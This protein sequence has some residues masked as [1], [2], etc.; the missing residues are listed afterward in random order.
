M[1]KYYTRFIKEYYGSSGR[2]KIYL[3]SKKKWV[4]KYFLNA[5]L[6]WAFSFPRMIRLHSKLL[7]I[8]LPAWNVLF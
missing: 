5:T 8:L 7:K 1:V 6:N 2:V 4:F 3:E